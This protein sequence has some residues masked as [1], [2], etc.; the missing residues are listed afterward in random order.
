MHEH[1]FKFIWYVYQWG[2]DK[3]VY[4]ACTTSASLQ[5]H[6]ATTLSSRV[7][8][9]FLK[10]EKYSVTLQC[11]CLLS[12]SQD[13]GRRP[14]ELLN[15]AEYMSYQRV[16]NMDQY[17]ESQPAPAYPPVTFLPQ[18]PY[19]QHPSNEPTYSNTGFPAHGPRA[20]FTFPKEQ[21]V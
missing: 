21:S 4:N 13:S 7:Q 19:A 3:Y 6:T 9:S 8:S 11:F 2:N 15:P 16:C 10:K 17:P 20:P 12:S 18:H 5:E 1:A 14:E